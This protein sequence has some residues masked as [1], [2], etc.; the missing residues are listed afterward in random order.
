MREASRV[1]PLRVSITWCCFRAGL[2]AQPQKLLN[3]GWSRSPSSSPSYLCNT[4]FIYHTY[5]PAPS[6]F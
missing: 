6:A 3:C 5:V 4:V 1:C 2:G